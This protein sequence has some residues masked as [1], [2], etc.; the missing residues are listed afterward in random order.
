MT[1]WY[2]QSGIPAIEITK[3]GAAEQGSEDEERR[4]PQVWDSPSCH[5]CAHLSHALS[6]FQLFAES[7]PITSFHFSVYLCCHLHLL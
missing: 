1:V 4:R 3:E 5:R 2:Q 6:Q 7:I